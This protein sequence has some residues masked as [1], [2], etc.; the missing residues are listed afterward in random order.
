[1]PSP[2]ARG[3]L[4]RY[5]PDR[6]ALAVPRARHGFRI[7][8]A[9]ALEG[10][11]PITRRYGPGTE[12]EGHLRLIRLCQIRLG[13]DFFFCGMILSEN[14]GPLFGI[15]PRIATSPQ[16]SPRSPAAPDRRRKRC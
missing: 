2:A 3:L 1:M 7:G 12:R 9:Y 15:M 11:E 14:R 16:P 4:S 10:G 5:E 13:A 6:P 8:R